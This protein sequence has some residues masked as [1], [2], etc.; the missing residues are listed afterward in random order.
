MVVDAG[1]D[2]DAGEELGLDGLDAAAYGQTNSGMTAVRG[3]SSKIYCRWAGLARP[4]GRG[5]HGNRLE[6]SMTTHAPSSSRGRRLYSSG[7][8]DEEARGEG[9][10]AGTSAPLGVDEAQSLP[11]ILEMEKFTHDYVVDGSP[12]TYL[13]AG[14]PSHVTIPADP[15]R[16]YRAKWLPAEASVADPNIEQ[17]LMLPD[18]SRKVLLSTPLDE[19][20]DLVR[21]VGALKA[22]AAGEETLIASFSGSPGLWPGR[23]GHG[24]RWQEAVATALLGSWSAPLLTGG[25]ITSAHLDQL[26]AEA[27]AIH[28]QLTPMWHRKVGGERLWSLDRDFGDGMTAYDVLRG[29]PD[30]H[31]VL[32]GALVDDPRISAVLAH[33]TPLERAVALAYAGPTMPTWTEAAATVAAAAPHLLAGTD[34]AALGERVRRK[35]R[36]LGVRHTARREAAA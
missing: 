1:V 15:H 16:V 12:I 20:P 4:R 30:P 5:S 28:R 24:A 19:E 27:R 11:R 9:A 33:L 21:A 18:G 36:R 2:P 23:R 7:G 29:G 14:S 3:K 13:R 26:R 25:P 32:F 22:A 10:A 35:L 31:E 17:E 6:N 8:S 34:E